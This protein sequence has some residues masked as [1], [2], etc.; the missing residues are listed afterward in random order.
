MDAGE[1]AAE[2]GIVRQTLE[3]LLVHFAL[4]EVSLTAHS[5]PSNVSKT[6]RIAE[7]FL[8]KFNY[9]KLTEA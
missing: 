6:V 4:E 9:S 2:V 8:Y 1:R 5:E 7:N 3:K